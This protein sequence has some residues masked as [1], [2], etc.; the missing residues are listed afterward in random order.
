MGTNTTRV[1]TDHRNLLFLFELL[2]VKHVILLN[3]QHKVQHWNNFLSKFPYLIKQI[4]VGSISLADTLT[5]W[6]QGYRGDKKT[7]KALSKLLD[8][9]FR[10][11]QLP[12][13]SHGQNWTSSGNTKMSRKR[14]VLAAALVLKLRCGK[15][16]VE[17]WPQRTDWSCI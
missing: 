14:A 12:I 4:A 8:T 11:F 2:A 6:N 16:K 13:K 10:S 9:A 1:Y 15:T 17:S 5:K 7:M 3:I